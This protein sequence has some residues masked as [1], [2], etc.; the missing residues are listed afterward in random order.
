[1]TQAPYDKPTPPSQAEQ[2]ARTAANR[3]EAALKDVTHNINAAQTGVGPGTGRRAPLHH[4]E[5][6]PHF[7][8]LSRRLADALIETAQN[9]VNTAA[10]NLE[11]IKRWT[12]NMQA[13]AQRKWEEMQELERRFEDY[14]SYI[15]QANDRFNGGKK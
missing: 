8:Q 9:Q 14:R 5:G 7:V 6:L 3:V 2:V 4:N 11:E 15:L 13:E 12:D 1:M 10:N